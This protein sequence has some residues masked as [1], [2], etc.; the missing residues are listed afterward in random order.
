MDHVL[1]APGE[2]ASVAPK[3]CLTEGHRAAR[4]AFARREAARD[5]TCV[6]FSDECLV[7]KFRRQSKGWC[8]P[9]ELKLRLTVKH[10][11]RHNVHACFEYGGRTHLLLHGEPDRDLMARILE[12][13]I[14]PCGEEIFGLPAGQWPSRTTA[15]QGRPIRPR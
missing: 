13:D 7:V 3:P 12:E 4:L 11:Q 10:P 9:G 6:L 15:T 2:W 14:V 1:P 8:L 5:W